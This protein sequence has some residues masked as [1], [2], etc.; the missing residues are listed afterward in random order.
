MSQSAV[1]IGGNADVA[2]INNGTLDE[3]LAASA[4]GTHGFASAAVTLTQAV[5]QE[6]NATGHASAML[7]NSGTIEV[8]MLASAT[9]TKI[10]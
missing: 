4:R 5:F 7:D 2:F 10:G 6:A 9:A 3:T 8:G 1:A